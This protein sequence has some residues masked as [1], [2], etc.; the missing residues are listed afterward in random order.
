MSS[1]Q[2]VTPEY[3]LKKLSSALSMPGINGCLEDIMNFRWEEEFVNH[4]SPEWMEPLFYLYTCPSLIE[5][6]VTMFGDEDWQIF[7]GDLLGQIMRRFP[8]QMLAR[9]GQMLENPETR[10][11][12][13]NALGAYAEPDALPCYEA[14]AEHTDE[15]AEEE[16]LCLIAGLG[17]VVFRASKEPV[18]QEQVKADAEKALFYLGRVIPITLTEAHQ[19]LGAY[20]GEVKG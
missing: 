10:R 9:I 1:E 3:V 15:L 19:Q 17:S 11:L 13:L 4:A 5:N 16:A 12:A 8:E 6:A 7:A 14:L 20:G 18:K 2:P